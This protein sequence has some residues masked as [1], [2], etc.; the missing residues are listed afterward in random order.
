[1]NISSFLVTAADGWTGQGLHREERIG[2]DG[3]LSW[4]VPASPEQPVPGLGTLLPDC[5]EREISNGVLYM[6]TNAKEATFIRKLHFGN[7]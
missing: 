6:K 3:S 4:T 1:M 2:G 7:N 5:A